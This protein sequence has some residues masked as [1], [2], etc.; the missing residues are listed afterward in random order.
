[1]LIMN[2]GSEVL[3]QP[4]AT[5]RCDTPQARGEPLA[6]RHVALTWSVEQGPILTAYLEAAGARVTPLF[7]GAVAPVGDTAALDAALLRLDRYD[8]AVLTSLA[9]VDALAQRLSALGIGPEASR[10]VYIAMLIPV[11]ARAREL[12][13][14]PPQLVPAAVLA[15][16]IAAGLRDITG[17]RILL[18]R[19]EEM[20][21]TLAAS[22]RRRGAEIDEVSAYRMI[23]RPVDAP[24]LRRVLVRSRVD[25]VVCTSA[26]MAE[27]L[28]AGLA[29]M[30][31]EPAE[32]LQAVPLIAL[33]AAAATPLRRAG[34]APTVAVSPAA[35]EQAAP[36]SIQSLVSAVVEV[37]AGE[38]GGAAQQAGHG[39][40]V[41]SS[42]VLGHTETCKEEGV[43]L[44]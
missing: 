12:V 39:R 7:A 42:R 24:S 38:R 16:D 14:L 36:P 43:S 21:V 44:A 9:G 23:A 15:D 32:A 25:T 1:M 28:L 3:P 2:S 17:K 35:T 10:R 26:V 6:G 5:G 34:L 13:A 31:Q 22:L 37:G 27:G 40:R 11:T 8:R 18:L 41:P 30:G 20:H 4:Q 33:D 19:A 29:A